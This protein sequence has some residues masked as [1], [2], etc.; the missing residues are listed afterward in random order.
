MELDELI[1]GLDVL[2]IKAPVPQHSIR[3]S[4]AVPILLATNASNFAI[5]STGSTATKADNYTLCKLSPSTVTIN[6]ATAA[7]SS[8]NLDRTGLNLDLSAQDFFEVWWHTP[9]ET[10]VNGV[11]LFFASDASVFT[12]YGYV[13][14]SAGN[15]PVYASLKK[16]WNCMRFL[17]SDFTITGSPNWSAIKTIRFQV[18]SNAGGA[19]ATLDSIWANCK[20]RA[21]C[22]VVFDDGWPEAYDFNSGYGMFTYMQSKG[23]K[24]GMGIIG[25]VIGTSSALSH[26]QLKAI[27]DAGWDLLTHGISYNGTSNNYQA[28]TDFPAEADAITN[29]LENKMFLDAM[30]FTRASNL[31]VFPQGKYT[32]TMLPTLRSNGFKLGRSTYEC[33]A[34]P[35]FPDPEYL[36]KLPAVDHGGKTFAQIK[37][38]IDRAIATGGSLYI[39]GHRIQ[40]AAGATGLFV[41]QSE[42]TQTIDYLA[43]QSANIDVVTPSQWLASVI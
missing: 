6:G 36:M 25:G 33:C 39:Y 9:D 11:S 17:K 8:T 40:T 19:I 16:G 14:V 27:Y 3:Q 37:P 12:N 21:K 22:M 35:Y 23:L 32:E 31:Y 10:K 34:Y 30:G 2:G 38:F 20:T 29:T 26:S 15:A 24:G 41:T 42:F 43:A 1:V 13:N 5:S 4:A 28:L 18:Y 7:S